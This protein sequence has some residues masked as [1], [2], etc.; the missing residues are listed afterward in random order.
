M[1]DIAPQTMKKTFPLRSLFSFGMLLVLSFLILMVGKDTQRVNK[2]MVVVED[3]EQLEDFW[4]PPPKDAGP[5]R[6][7][8]LMI[9]DFELF[10]SDDKTALPNF[11]FSSPGCHAIYKSPE[12]EVQV[13]V[14]PVE[15]KGKELLLEQMDAPRGHTSYHI[16]GKKCNLSPF[17]EYQYHL[18]WKKDW[19][20]VVFT[21]SKRDQEKFFFD[22]VK[23]L[24]GP[25]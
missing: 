6:L 14:Y 2:K 19:L 7:F 21:M 25:Q 12:A 23:V 24:G 20:I 18:C 8:P 13:F 1:A 10:S 3:L 5:A 15:E 16:C 22:Y 4:H 11:K 17:Y 9:G